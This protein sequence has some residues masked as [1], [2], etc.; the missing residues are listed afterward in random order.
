MMLDSGMQARRMPALKLLD[1]STGGFALGVVRLKPGAKR[2]L[3]AVGNWLTGLDPK[4]WVVMH[5]MHHEHSDTPKDPHS[6]RYYA[7]PASMM[8]S[9][10]K[11]YDAICDGTAE[12][13]PR[14]LGGYPEWP[15][16]DRM[17][18]SE[19][20]DREG[21]VVAGLRVG[22]QQIGGGITRVAAGAAGTI[23]GD[24][25]HTEMIIRN[26]VVEI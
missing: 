2:M 6:P 20:E 1:Q 7:G 18:P 4:A 23:S 24:S 11:R 12:V 3:L 10:A 25:D 22:R 13:E 9:T 26:R 19:E 21:D 8:L 16:L 5:R 17:S 15:T 14:F